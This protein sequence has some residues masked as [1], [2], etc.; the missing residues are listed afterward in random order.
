MECK[1][2]NMEEKHHVLQILLDEALHKNAEML[3]EKEQQEEIQ[4]KT[5]LILQEFE[6]KNLQLHACYNEMHAKI[7]E[8]EGEKEKLEKIM[9]RHAI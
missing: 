3:Q 6:R 7:I 5:Q 8:L 1:L 4:K 9:L 2:Q